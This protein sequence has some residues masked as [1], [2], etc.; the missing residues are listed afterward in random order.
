MTA[1]ENRQLMERIFVELAEG[2]HQLF[3][4]SISDDLRWIVV[5]TTEWSRTYEGWEDVRNNLFRPIRAQFAGVQTLTADRF[6]ASDDYV[7][8]EFRGNV[9]TQ[10]GKPYLG[11][12]VW[13]CHFKKGQLAEVTEYLDT[14]RFNAAIAAPATV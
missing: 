10:A 6:I 4:D 13:V 9:T 12:Y 5:G 8:V 7:V 14:A 1:T 3:L 2:K 11:V